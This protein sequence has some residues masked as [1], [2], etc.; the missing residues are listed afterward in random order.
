[1]SVGDLEEVFLHYRYAH[2]EGW[3]VRAELRLDEVRTWLANEATPPQRALFDAL[4]KNP[5]AFEPENV[6]LAALLVHFVVLLD[7]LGR[8]PSRDELRETFPFGLWQ[9]K[10]PPSQAEWQAAKER[11]KKTVLDAAERQAFKRNLKALGLEALPA[12]TL[13]QPLPEGEGEDPFDV[14]TGQA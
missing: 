3:L 11:K 9:D 13:P 8:L 6:Q 14:L 2:G 5:A 10:R 4:R 7:K 12:G 1:V